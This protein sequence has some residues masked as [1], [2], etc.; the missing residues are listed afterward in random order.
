MMAEDKKTVC[1]WLVCLTVLVVYI[2]LFYYQFNF[3]SKM[4]FYAFY[5]SAHAYFVD[6]NPYIN[7]VTNE[8]PGKDPLPANLNPPFFLELMRLFIFDSA[9]KSI[10]T[11]TLVNV[12]LGCIGALLIFK[13]LFPK[14]YLKK[15]AA[16]LL[17]LYLILFPI[18]MNTT[19]TQ[20]GNMLVFFVIL[21]YCFF[22]KDK[23]IL[24]GFCWGL[25]TAVKLFPAL[26]FFFALKH[27][28][29]SL[30]VTMALTFVLAWILPLLTHGMAPYLNFFNMQY[31]VFWYGDSWNSS[32]LAMLF[33]LL[34][35][36]LEPL[37]H[38]FLIRNLFAVLFLIVLGWYLWKLFT[39][40]KKDE[41]EAIELGFC[42]TLVMML[43]L[44]PFGWVYYFSLLL[45]PLIVSWQYL[46]RRVLAWQPPSSIWLLTF[47][48]LNFPLNYM[49]Q[50]KVAHWAIAKT[51]IPLLFPLFK[52][53][54]NSV[55]FFG[56]IGL[57]WFITSLLGCRKTKNLQ[58]QE[59]IYLSYPIFHIIGFGFFVP[60]LSFI[61]HLKS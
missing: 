6:T 49:A 7:F 39:F 40:K 4:D 13:L 11:W 18:C 26:L 5:A 14:E 61:L 10:A 34:Y 56:L 42:F 32:I 1:K 28:R 31:G 60:L 25:I 24:A 58:M 29:Y 38:L 44:S 55:H 43:I 59:P 2:I 57:A 47:F 48:L 51:K 35:D 12:A 41:Q 53:T 37:K 30:L 33:R 8:M 16:F 22:L 36:P 3:F 54:I 21:G 17:S 27:K 23:N 46:N 45:M 15:N 9:F 20:V 19:I 52:M 50:K